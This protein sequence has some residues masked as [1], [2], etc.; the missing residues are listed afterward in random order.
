MHMNFIGVSFTSINNDL[1]VAHALSS[2]KLRQTITRLS[3]DRQCE[4][5]YILS[6]NRQCET[7]YTLTSDR[8]FE[9]PNT[10][11]CHI[12]TKRNISWSEY[13]SHVTMSSC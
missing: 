4:A 9:T 8:Q 6:S 5:L 1:Q 13:Q 2:N 11:S 10:L 3:S 7:L 12:E